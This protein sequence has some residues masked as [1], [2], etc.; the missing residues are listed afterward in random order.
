[1]KLVTSNRSLVVF[2]VACLAVSR[3]SLRSFLAER[4]PKTY[5]RAL[6]VPLSG[7]GCKRGLHRYCH[8]HSLKQGS[9]W[10][11][12]PLSTGGRKRGL[13]RNCHHHSLKVDLQQGSAWLCVPLSSGGRKRGLHRNCHHHSLKTYSRALPGSASLCPVV[14]A[15]EACT[16]I[17]ITIVSSE[18]NIRRRDV[19]AFPYGPD[20]LFS[21]R[22]H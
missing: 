8:H 14:V 16:V 21:S 5:R 13:H 6:Y 22:E 18:E 19:L 17:A 20:Q 15:S 9:A 10:L 11:C 1:M 12:V 2:G 3:R 4:R 7:G